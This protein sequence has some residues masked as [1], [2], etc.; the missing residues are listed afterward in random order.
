MPRPHL[1]QL[2]EHHSIAFREMNVAERELRQAKR[3][4]P[5]TSAELL[6]HKIKA[7]TAASNMASARW[8]LRNAQIGSL[9]AELSKE[10]KTRGR[11]ARYHE[12]DSQLA[13][14]EKER[15]QA[16]ESAKK[17]SLTLMTLREK[18]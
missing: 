13:V 10:L 12:I 2:I 4:H 5:K 15:E 9:T 6:K 17:A 14:Y 18:K 8:K 3:T 11:T 7:V 16:A 1:R